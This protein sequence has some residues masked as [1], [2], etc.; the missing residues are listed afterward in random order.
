MK[1]PKKEEKIFCCKFHFSPNFILLS[2]N[3]NVA[4][5]GEIHFVMLDIV[6]ASQN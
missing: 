2:F 4:N 3:E 1:H 5:E 6:A